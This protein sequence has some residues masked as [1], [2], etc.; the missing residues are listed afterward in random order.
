[1]RNQIRQTRDNRRPAPF[2][3]VVT[4]D[5]IYAHLWPEYASGNG[6]DHPYDRQISDHKR[7]ITMGIKKALKGKDGADLGQPGELIKTWRKVGYM[8]DVKGKMTFV[9]A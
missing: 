8:L 1:M 4:R 6:S 2:S 9:L 3:Q 5:E 7:K